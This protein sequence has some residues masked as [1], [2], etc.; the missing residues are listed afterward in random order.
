[1]PRTETKQE[2]MVIE[3]ANVLLVGDRVNLFADQPNAPYGWGTVVA[4]TEDFAEV[5]RPYVHTADFTTGAAGSLSG[6]RVMSYMGQE[7]TRLPRDS[8]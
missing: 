4:V 3:R 5:V 7:T 8:A 2:K 1:M 6:E